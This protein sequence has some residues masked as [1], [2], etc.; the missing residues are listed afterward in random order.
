MAATVDIATLGIAIQ[1]DGIPTATS[2]LNDM[3]AAGGKADTSV[4]TLSSSFDT[5]N[6]YI[7]SSWDSFS[8]FVGKL[9]DSVSSI[10]TTASQRFP[11]LPEIVTAGVLGAIGNIVVQMGILPG[12]LG[13]AAAKIF[14]GGGAISSG[15]ESASTSMIA[16]LGV[17]ISSTVNTTIQTISAAAGGAMLSMMSM[18]GVLAISALFA[19]AIKSTLAWTESV[20]ALGKQLQMSSES[21]SAYKIALDE[22]KVSTSDFAGANTALIN[23]LNTNESAITDMGIATRTSTGELRSTADLL[24]EIN[25]K[26][27]G[28]KDNSEQNSKSLEIYGSRWSD[29]TGVMRINTTTMTDATK[30]SR[31]LG[32][33]V[34]Q[35]NVAA[36]LRYQ[37][38][39]ATLETT[40]KSLMI[41]TGQNL[42]PVFAD[43]YKVLADLA[44][45]VVPMLGTGLNAI[46]GV[47]KE[48]GLDFGM[49]LI[50]VDSVDRG[51]GNFVAG[52]L[53]AVKQNI[54]T[55]VDSVKDFYVQVKAIIL[56]Q[57]D[58]SKPVTQN[59]ATEAQ[60]AALARSLQIQL[61]AVRQQNTDKVALYKAD[62]AIQLSILKDTYDQGLITTQSYYDAEN[63]QAET[64]AFRDVQSAQAYLV[65]TKNIV[66]QMAD[67]KG[68]ASNE[69]QTALNAESQA[70]QAVQIAQLNLGKT[71]VEDSIKTTTAIRAQ[72]AEYQ[73]LITTTL[74]AQ[75]KFVAAEQHKQATYQQ[76]TQYLR[77]QAEAEAGNETAIT[78]LAAVQTKAALDMIDATTKEQAALQSI[79]DATQGNYTSY[80]QVLG[81][82]KEIV[83]VITAEYGEASKLASLQVE[84]SKAQDDPARLA[85]LQ[86]ELSS[87]QQLVAAKQIEAQLNAQKALQNEQFSVQQ[88][89][90][91]QQKLSGDTQGAALAQQQLDLQKQQ[92]TYQQQMIQDQEDLNAAQQAGLDA[93]VVGIQQL[94]QMQTTLNNITVANIQN[95]TMQTAT[96]STAPTSATDGYGSSWGHDANGNLVGDT[97]STPTHGTGTNT[98]AP[99]WGGGSSISQVGTNYQDTKAAQQAAQAAEQ[100]AAAVEAAT[101][102]MRQDV[103]ART[104]AVQGLT[105]EAAQQKLL[106]SDYQALIA[107]Q[108]QGVDTTKLEIVQT[109][110]YNKLLE[111]QQ[112]AKL[113]KDTQGFFDTL[114]TAISS[115]VSSGNTLVSSLRNSSTSL[116]DAAS[117]LMSGNQSNL[118]PEAQYELSRQTL[119]S[120]VQQAMANGDATLYAKIPQL[121]SGFL[122]Q[123]KAYNASGA[124]YGADFNWSKDLLNASATAADQ[125]AAQANNV[126][127]AAQKQQ[128]TLDAIKAALTNDDTAALGR[129]RT[130]LTSDNAN[131]NAAVNQ[132]TQSL[133]DTGAI[134][135]R[136]TT[137]FAADSPLVKANAGISVAIDETSGVLTYA[138]NTIGANGQAVSTALGQAGITIS[139]PFILGGAVPSALTANG[140]SVA[141]GVAASGA[142]IGGAVGGIPTA[143]SGVAAPFNSGGAFTSALTGAFGAGGT[144]TG[145]ITSG[146]TGAG[147]VKEALTGASNQSVT[148]WL[149]TNA[150]GLAAISADTQSLTTLFA[151]ATQQLAALKD[152]QFA[153]SAV[154]P[155]VSRLLKNEGYTLPDTSTLTSAQATTVSA[156]ASNPWMGIFLTAAASGAGISPALKLHASGGISDRPAIFGEAGPEAAVPLPDGRSIP[157]TLK[158]ADN[159]G[160]MS[161]ILAELKELRAEVARQ[162]GKTVDKL[163]SIE[164]PLRRVAAR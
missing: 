150:T 88:Q 23:T 2:R 35:D 15:M 146:L 117:G 29:L 110:E 133:S 59:S 32:M 89:I 86:A 58:P 132:T 114:K 98:P 138:S 90:I 129:L 65:A 127:S 104:L 131:L 124:Q 76:S 83:D 91:D 40:T 67:A 52:N 33:V 82:R 69:Y 54:S 41:S 94:M 92:A 43:F 126:I 147:S 100:Q 1:S 111:Q 27:L 13:T 4:N 25:T 95:R 37:T 16:A 49:L 44:T 159:Y 62:S 10:Y 120:T 48:I 122:T 121:V 116:R 96:A 51:I 28:M 64:A 30:Q 38:A 7:Q 136:F 80:L 55:W 61:Q 6:R 118:S 155:S 24:P 164:S 57:P 9:T 101:V 42:L 5:L 85:A 142:S 63:K 36:A 47:A 145:A 97:F 123:S 140:A 50:T 134:A 130:Q 137:S 56:Q 39:L 143:I 151:T 148:S 135:S 106:F 21:A 103:Q 157:V 153:N 66:Q 128:N 141:A 78:A 87:E 70:Q 160:D 12:V 60:T 144:A 154:T 81:V 163:T 72:V 102:A 112:I 84:I 162:G 8:S 18:V 152:A 31:Q 109:Q 34:G 156:P 93:Q 68:T 71:I 105:D 26:L 53:E 74:D 139:S 77:L 3:T 17:K 108:K 115:L 20:G 14:T 46:G 113:A 75:G 22:Q 119:A 19:E 73:G 45:I 99:F 107:A 161:A 11:M 125:A 158:R 79:N 149:Y